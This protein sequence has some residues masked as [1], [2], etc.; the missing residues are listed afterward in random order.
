[1]TK[2][3]CLWDR[4][5][6]AVQTGKGHKETSKISVAQ[7]I[8]HFTDHCV[9]P[10]NKLKYEFLSVSNYL[11]LAPC[12]DSSIFYKPFCLNRITESSVA[13]DFSMSSEPTLLKGQIEMFRC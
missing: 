12:E 5:C 13:A 6:D 2:S 10:R 7:I 1:M 11:F 8:R 4:I 9:I 3:V